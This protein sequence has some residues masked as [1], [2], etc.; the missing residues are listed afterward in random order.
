MI[1]LGQKV[2]DKVTGFEGVATAKLE[3]INGCIQYCVKPKIKEQGKM[4]EG[5]YIDHQQLEVLDEET[6]IEK[7]E[8]GGSLPD[9]PKN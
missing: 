1:K 7:D 9:Y 6:I 2:R 5:V 4:P 8:T 3:Y